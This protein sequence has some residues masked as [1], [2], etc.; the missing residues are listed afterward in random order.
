[1]QQ[2]IMNLSNKIKSQVIA[3]IM[4]S[5]FLIWDVFIFFNKTTITSKLLA[6]GSFIIL[7]S[8][9]ILFWN[10]TLK[11]IKQEKS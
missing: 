7:L 3:S 9:L 8:L 10:Q 4:L 6:A 11:N 1:M 5:A 2:K